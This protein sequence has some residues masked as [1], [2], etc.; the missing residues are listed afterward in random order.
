ME[1]KGFVIYSRQIGEKLR[2]VILYTDK[3]GKIGLIV[4]LKKGD[5]PLAVDLFSLSR[6]RVLQKGSEFEPQEFK[7][8]RPHFP[9]SEEEFFY[10]SK[11]CKLLF[12]FQLSPS[13]KLFSL[14]DR[15]FQVKSNFQL[16]YTMFLLKFSFVE[17]IFPRLGKCVSCG[18]QNFHHF[19]LEKGGVVC[20]RCLTKD[21]SLWSKSLSKLTLRL[22]KNPFEE[23]KNKTLS[24]EALNKIT[25]IFESHINYRLS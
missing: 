8:I 24:S 13:R 17:G 23:E 25:E 7:L 14:I 11:V 3:L 6:F 12:P 2:H 19:S 1:L 22:T 9:L 10:L 21:A 16:A 15:Y 20:N 18:S 5:F 4:K